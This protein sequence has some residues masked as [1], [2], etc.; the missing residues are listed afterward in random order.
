MK[1]AEVV[2]RYIEKLKA[3]KERELKLKE[4]YIDKKS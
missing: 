4:A 2:K 3:K 1:I